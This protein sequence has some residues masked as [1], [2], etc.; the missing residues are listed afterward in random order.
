MGGMS[1]AA[2]VFKGVGL[3]HAVEQVVHQFVEFHQRVMEQATAFHDLAERVDLGVEQ[4]QALRL[5]SINA[6]VSQEQLQTSLIRFNSAIGAA[7]QGSKLQIDAL[8]QLG[9]KIL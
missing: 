9:V 5:A 1:Q 3:E 4:Y 7:E 2:E 8:N 6:G